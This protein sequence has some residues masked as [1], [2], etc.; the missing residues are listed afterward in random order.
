MSPQRPSSEQPDVIVR[1]REIA[2]LFDKARIVATI[3]GTI[4]GLAFA[5]LQIREIAFGSIAQAAGPYALMRIAL[6][7]YYASW[8]A[9]QPFNI[10]MQMST[11]VGDPGRGKIPTELFFFIPMLLI[12]GMLLFWFSSNEKLIAVLI[13]LMLALDVAMWLKWTIWTNKVVDYSST[14]LQKLD[15]DPNIGFERLEVVRAYIAGAWNIGRFVLAIALIIGLDILAFST[16]IRGFVE[17]F[18]E[19][20]SSPDIARIVDAQLVGIFFMV[21]VICNEVWV[22]WV[23]IKTKSQV[24]FLDEIQTKYKLVRHDQ[25]Y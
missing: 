3:A 4:M 6:V 22:W 17:K 9:A 1:Y 13:S 21:F 19:Q 14:I 25:E 18:L 5:F 16:E 2:K 20:R 15:T 24:D 11:F 7:I 23:R 10:N 8:T 12:L